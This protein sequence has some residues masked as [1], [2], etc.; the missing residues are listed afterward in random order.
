[1]PLL[2]QILLSLVRKLMA[3]GSLELADGATAES[4]AREVQAA[5]AEAAPFSQAGPALAQVLVDSEQVEELYCS[6]EDVGDALKAIT[7]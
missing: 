1:M 5:L 3:D 2:D 7:P 4:L 6:D